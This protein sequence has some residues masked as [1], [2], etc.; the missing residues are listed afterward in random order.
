MLKFLWKKMEEIIKRLREVG[1]L[2]RIYYVKAKT[3][4]R[5]LHSLGRPRVL[6]CQ[7][8]KESPD[9][10]TSIGDLVMP[11]RYRSWITEQPAQDTAHCD[12]NGMTG[13]LKQLRPGGS[14]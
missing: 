3:S 8:H 2:K 11:V 6:V 10:I 1:M 7:G 14:A 9:E 13:V 12:S 4:T 5:F